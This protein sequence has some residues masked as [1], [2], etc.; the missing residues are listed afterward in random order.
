MWEL[1]H[2]ESWASKNWCFLILVLEKTLESPLDF[3]EIKPVNP[4]GNQPWI[5]IGR[6]D[7]EAPILWPP[8]A[9]SWP[10][11]KDSDAGKDWGQ[12]GKGGQRTR[13][14]NG[15]TNSRDMS[16][17][18]LWDIVKDREA[19]HAT[20]HGVAKSWTWISDW[21]KTIRLSS[22]GHY[23]RSLESQELTFIQNSVKN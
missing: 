17:S 13:R 14:L 8:D 12:E 7:A 10:T 2:K 1:D 22:L 20:V 23:I 3:K 19:W 9:K 16:L 6:A 15:N 18:K 11:G 4:K 21:T 5:F